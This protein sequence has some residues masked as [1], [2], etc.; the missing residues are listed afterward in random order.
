MFH[1]VQRLRY[2][3]LAGVDAESLPAA[4]L[5]L[6]RLVELDA[7]A[8]RLSDLAHLGPGHGGNGAVGM[9]ELRRLNLS[10]NLFAHL[11]AHSWHYLPRLKS[12]DVSH[13]PIRV[14]TKESFYGLGRLQELTVRHLPELKRFDADSLA[15]L[16][17][18]RRLLIQS[19]PSIERYKFRLGAVVSG[20]SSLKVLSA[21][22]LED[23]LSDQ[24]ETGETFYY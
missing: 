18:L 17:F 1:Y 11:P 19:W 24:V 14:L 9:P 12:L 23:R 2:L 22:I 21:R 6:P 16:G 5:P 20:L 8:N 3:G 13:N 10:S 4:S 7:G 15:E